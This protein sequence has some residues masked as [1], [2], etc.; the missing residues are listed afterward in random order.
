MTTTPLTATQ[1]NAFDLMASTLAAWGLSTLSGDL[2]NL[3]VKGDTQADTLSLALTQTAAYKQRFAGNALRVKQGL[4]ELNPAQ[5]IALEESY[6][7]ILR[8][9]GMP[10][11]YYDKPEDFTKFI[12]NDVS[13]AEIQTR[14]QIAHDMYTNAPDSVKSLWGQYFGTKGDAIAFI[15]DP[16]KAT[17]VI[18]DKANQVGIGGAAA[19]VGLTVGQP[20]AQQ[21]QQAGVTLAGAQKAY[22]QIAQ[23]MPTDQAIAARFGQTFGQSQEENDLLLGQGDASVLRST[24]YSEE[25]GLF[26]D[27]AGM[28]DSSLSVNQ[29]H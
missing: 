29:S 20:R 8:S 6:S 16:D 12:G 15:L 23:A 9:Y 28:T 1:Q 11:G 24:L 4:A 22:Q 3:I 27:K 10:S 17:Q 19:Q 14:A 21:L 25:K 7:N 18:Q 5:Y 13:P 26:S 2:R